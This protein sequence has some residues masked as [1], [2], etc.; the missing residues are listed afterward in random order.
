V[1]TAKDII[2]ILLSCATLIAIIWGAIKVINVAEK[3]VDELD[4]RVTELEIKQSALL[5]NTVE[6][7][8]LSG[9]VEA[10]TDEIM[11][12][13]NRLDKFLDSQEVPVR[14]A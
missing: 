6:V 9:K 4:R 10:M 12:V 3:K 2:Q 14:R 11:R 13:R 1:N 7:A 8:K 5:A